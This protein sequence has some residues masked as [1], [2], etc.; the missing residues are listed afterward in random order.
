MRTM[1]V[2]SKVDERGRVVIPSRFRKSMKTGYVEVRQEGEKLLL[3]PSRDPLDLL[4][5]K[6]SRAK[7]LK[8]LSLAAEQEAER[9]AKERRRHANS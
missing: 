2:V 7:P 6:V 9:L 5:R 1:G 4:R 3:L 8:S